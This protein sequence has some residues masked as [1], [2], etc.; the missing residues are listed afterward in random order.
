MHLEGGGG[1]GGGYGVW[2]VISL[3]ALSMRRG[4]CEFFECYDA[5]ERSAECRSTNITALRHHHTLYLQSVVSSRG[6]YLVRRMEES[7]RTGGNKSKI[8]KMNYPVV[9]YI[10]ISICVEMFA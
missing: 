3:F 8:L 6:I 5:T 7:P 2:N 10:Y 4:I 1:A 9:V